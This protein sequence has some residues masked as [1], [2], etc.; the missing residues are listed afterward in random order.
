[1]K[2]SQKAYQHT[3]VIFLGRGDCTLFDAWN[4]FQLKPTSG[5]PSGLFFIWDYSFSLTP[6]L[7]GWHRLCGE[8][9]E[10]C[11]DSRLRG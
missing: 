8:E 5:N 4:K 9:L 6:Q 7:Y 10:A 1:M 3:D 11:G 2:L